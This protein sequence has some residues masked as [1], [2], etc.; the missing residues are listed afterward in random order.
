MIDKEVDPLIRFFHVGMA[1]QT[2]EASVHKM[3]RSG[4]LPEPAYATG[5]IRQWRLS[6][7]R[8]ANPGLADSVQRLLEF[9]KTAA[10]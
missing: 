6:Q 10:A 2:C 9:P 1:L 4:R 3:I 7:L 5:R 8:E